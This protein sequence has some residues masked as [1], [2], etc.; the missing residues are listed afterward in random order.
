MAWKNALLC[1][2]VAESVSPKGL[3]KTFEAVSKY[4]KN[5]LYIHLYSGKLEMGIQVYKLYAY[6]MIVCLVVS[7]H[8]PF[9]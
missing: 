2:N 6:Q 5:R 4:V 9:L 7:R 3:G 1:L 8:I